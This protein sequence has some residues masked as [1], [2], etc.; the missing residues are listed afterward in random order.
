MKTSKCSVARM[1]GKG[2]EGECGRG[3]KVFNNPQQ[4][5]RR[6]HNKEGSSEERGKS[7]NNYDSTHREKKRERVGREREVETETL[8]ESERLGAQVAQPPTAA[9]MTYKTLTM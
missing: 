8:R 3:Q 9:I 7:S 6:R 5:T 4:Q 1:G 2:G